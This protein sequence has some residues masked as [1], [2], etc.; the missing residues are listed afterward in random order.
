M[1]SDDD[2]NEDM[3]EPCD[4]VDETMSV[5]GDPGDGSPERV[6]VPPPSAI[7]LA[8][9]N[10]HGPE[11]TPWTLATAAQVSPAEVDEWVAA[12]QHA[13]AAEN[14][15]SDSSDSS[16]NSSSESSSSEGEEAETWDEV[17][18]RTTAEAAQRMED[19]H[20]EGEDIGA[21]VPVQAHRRSPRQGNVRGRPRESRRRDGFPRVPRVP[22][23]PRDSL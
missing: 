4:V 8:S 3:A 16:E 1:K 9:E 17:A 13:P 2:L 7:G 19:L 23:G 10:L 5:E 18:A 11:H 22:R 12:A 6:S 15:A 14:P 20:G 21:I